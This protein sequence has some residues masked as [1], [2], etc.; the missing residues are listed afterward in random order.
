[1]TGRELKTGETFYA[2]VI[3]DG[4]TLVRR[5][6]AAD[7]WPGP[8]EQAVAY[9][10]GRVPA[11]DTPARPPCDDDLL[12]DCLRRLDGSDDPDHV[13]LRYVIAL[14]LMRRKR[15]RLEEERDDLPGS[16]MVFHD[17]KGGGRFE[18]RDP[19]LTADDL[20]AAQ[21]E[22]FRLLGWD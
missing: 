10:V 3:D 8:P 18:I 17:A 14:L 21:D 4:A 19:G 15:L 12:V 7:A 1:V 13:A 20:R 9:W 5:D 16:V 11:T 22:L 2:A 6:F